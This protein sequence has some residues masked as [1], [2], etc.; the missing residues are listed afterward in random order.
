[1]QYALYLSLCIFFR[2]TESL[3]VANF[4]RTRFHLHKETYDS[5]HSIVTQ[6]N[7]RKSLRKDE[8]QRLR[9][10]GACRDDNIA[11][12]SRIFVP[13]NDDDD[14]DD[15]RSENWLQMCVILPGR[16]A[17]YRRIRPTSIMHAVPVEAAGRS[18]LVS[19]ALFPT[20]L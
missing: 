12:L 20:C 9:S 6:A 18:T 2:K 11:S 16:A 14:V 5:R 13:F 7:R 8:G 19:H 15:D 4:R 10:I 17:Y 3:T 1:M